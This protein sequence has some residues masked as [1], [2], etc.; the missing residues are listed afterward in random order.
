MLHVFV[1]GNTQQHVEKLL[2]A[3]MHTQLQQ[4]LPRSCCGDEATAAIITVVPEQADTVFSSPFASCTAS[5]GYSL[6][7]AKS[8]MR[9]SSSL[10]V[11]SSSMQ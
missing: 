8:D 5:H 6:H 10:Q 9:V 3:G 2:C 4:A 1:S 7:R 11:A